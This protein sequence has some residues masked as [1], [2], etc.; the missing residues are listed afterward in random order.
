MLKSIG[1][2]RPAFVYLGSHQM[3]RTSVFAVGRLRTST[4]SPRRRK[5][6]AVSQISS[7]APLPA[8]MRS[9]AICSRAASDA[10]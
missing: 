1:F 10:R 9:G 4:R 3:G 6:S 7:E 5:A 2:P 8:R